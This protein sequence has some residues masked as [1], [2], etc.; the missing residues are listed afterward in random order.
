MFN[1]SIE[2]IDILE[3]GIPKTVLDTLL[4]DHST[5]KNIFWGTT[6]YEHYGEGFGDEWENNYM[7]EYG[8]PNY[9]DLTLVDAR[10]DVYDTELYG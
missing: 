3:G 2:A 10:F 5:Q 7:I 1:M 4:Q 9:N 8:L 6:D